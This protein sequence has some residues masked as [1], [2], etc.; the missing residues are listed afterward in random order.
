M[1]SSRE[2]VSADL[3]GAEDPVVSAVVAVALCM[4]LES[5]VRLRTE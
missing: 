2:M 4:S 5:F 1:R 3:G